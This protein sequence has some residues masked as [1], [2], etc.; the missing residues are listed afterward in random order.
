MNGNI[1]ST[2]DETVDTVTLG[3]LESLD[4]IDATAVRPARSTRVLAIGFAFCCYIACACIYFL[5][6]SNP[7]VTLGPARYT[8]D[9]LLELAFSI[10]ALP[11]FGVTYVYGIKHHEVN[12]DFPVP[13]V[14]IDF[15]IMASI[16]WVAVGNGIHL[17][18]KLDEQL[19]A[20]LKDSPALGLRANF[21]FI[22]QEVGHVFPHI[23]WNLLFAALMLGQLKRPYWGAKPKSAVSFFGTL[24]GLLFAHGAI[25]GCC[26][27]VG[28]VLM[29]ISLVVFAYL[30]YKSKLRP[31]EL[32]ILNFFFCSQIT[33]LLAMV[34]YW[35]LFHGATI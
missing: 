28:F 14:V 27:H 35:T 19:V 17:T 18:A 16:V 24:L 3:S 23:G 34:I 31:G 2:A 5:R 10:L 33:F 1:S 13:D 21:H 8:V 22:R 4:T 20:G 15:L 7:V 6:P 29:G 32:P 30:G 26:T 12:P 25:A 11:A 9:A